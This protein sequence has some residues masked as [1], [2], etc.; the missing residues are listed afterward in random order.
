MRRFVSLCIVVVLLLVTF[1]TALKLT[2]RNERI[3]RKLFD[4]LLSETQASTHTYAQA[5]QYARTHPKR[6]NGSWNQ[7][8]CIIIHTLDCDTYINIYL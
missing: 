6:D 1:T 5:I 2:K 3:V 8:Y 4:D 7:W